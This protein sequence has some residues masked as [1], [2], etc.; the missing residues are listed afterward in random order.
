MHKMDNEQKTSQFCKVTNGNKH[1]Q[2]GEQGLKR[3]VR[4]GLCRGDFL[5]HDGAILG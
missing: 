3:V 4:E 1:F 5:S 2:A